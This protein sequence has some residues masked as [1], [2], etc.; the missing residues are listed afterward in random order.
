MAII[1][2]HFNLGRVVGPPGPPSYLINHTET[3][4]PNA[5]VHDLGINDFI[6]EISKDVQYAYGITKAG[7][8]CLITQQID[9][10]E[11]TGAFFITCIKSIMVILSEV[12]TN[13][14][15]ASDK[16]AELNIGQR[17][18][19]FNNIYAT[20]FYYTWLGGDGQWYAAKAMDFAVDGGVPY[21]TLGSTN[22]QFKSIKLIASNL[23]LIG[24]KYKNTITG[25][26]LLEVGGTANIFG[27]TIKIGVRSTS[28]LQLG[29]QRCVYPDGSQWRVPHNGTIQF[30][31]G[32]YAN[33]EGG[34]PHRGSAKLKIYTSTG[35][36]GQIEVPN[37]QVDGEIKLEMWLP[38][39]AEGDDTPIPLV[40]KKDGIYFNGIKQAQSGT[41]ESFAIQASAWTALADKSPFTYSATVIAAAP[42]GDDTMVELTNS[43]AVA[44]AKY[45][46]SIGAVSGQSITVYS[47]GAPTESTVLKIK[48]GG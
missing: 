37:D 41:V 44:F 8:L 10:G 9:G 26:Y 42:I 45:G 23:T 24:D 32:N 29:F 3:L 2:E 5:T 12:S 34:E 40:I 4:E 38:V 1:T 27:D 39:T 47:V 13:I 21:I 46:F 48:I 11:F 35:G 15:P 31:P 28:Y 18:R 6:P 22:T 19:P 36:R 33:V 43:D 7:D 17:T 14:T 20:D 30:F 25:D 16:R